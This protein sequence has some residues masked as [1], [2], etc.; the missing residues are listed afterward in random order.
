MA[1]ILA[2]IDEAGYGPLLG[3]LCVG[4]AVF[5]IDHW[6][7][8]EGAPDL[9]AMLSEGVCRKPSDKRRRVAVED[10]KKLKLANSS[11]THH[12]LTHLE[13]GVLAFL[14]AAGAR[15]S[16]DL[17]LFDVLTAGREPHPWYS[18][19]GRPVPV[20]HDPA[21][22]GIAANE[23]AR[24]MHAA[25]IELAALR[26]RAIGERMFNDVVDQ[27]GTKAAATELAIGSFLRGIWEKWGGEE[28]NPEGGPRVVCDRQG[29]RT[30][31]APVLA[32]LVP[33]AEVAVLDESARCCRYR[34][35]GDG[36]TMTVLFM[37]EAEGEYLPVA[38]AS[39]AAKYTRELMMARFNAY[40]CGLC[41]E[42]KP[43]AG[44]TQ[45][46]R[47]WLR[48]AVRAGVLGGEDRRTMVRRA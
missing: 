34:L 11:T 33:G 44:Y 21:Q 18:G 26:C 16:T 41:P 8:S 38:L 9:W 10:S 47:R 23:V 40:W 37:T 17:E 43:T 5:R 24:A 35:S 15:P 7:Q 22:I 20:A 2:G 31:Y 14:A 13:R 27:T 29:G 45:D 46:A 3:P 4:A 28:D 48:D 25:G 39:M 32:R 36:K 42:L 12:P 1:L 6:D 30:N 19:G